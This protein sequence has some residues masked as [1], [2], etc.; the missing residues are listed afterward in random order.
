MTK[1]AFIGGT[2]TCGT[3]IM[4][5]ILSLHPKVASHSFEYRF[6]I[7]PDGIIDFYTTALHCWSPYIMDK[8]LRRLESF[9]MVLA[10]R[11]EGKEIYVNWELNKHFLGYEDAVRELMDELVDFKYKGIHYG[12]RG[13]RDIYYMVYRTK[14]EL[15]RI[16]GGF[17]RR[18]I[19]GYLESEGKELYVEDNTFNPLFSR[20]ILDL[21]PEAKFIHMLREPKDVIASLSKQ[22][23]APKDKIKSAIWTRNILDRINYL[24]TKIPGD[25]IITIDLYDLVD[26]TEIV[27][28]R[29][30]DFLK[31]PF[32]RRLLEIDLG[33]SHR[34]RWIKDF[35]SEELNS[36]R[37]ILY[38]D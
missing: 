2:G 9:L 27:L 12:I 16:L 10:K 14:K 4:K 8:K 35:S 7:D 30:C 13:K 34:D 25:S 33:R 20:D 6:I 11:Y 37:K 36:I 22:R 3:N 28:R 24:K 32:H 31:I 5:E 15:S 23:W 17:I 26:D 1:I 38:P 18:L 21:L 19:D 29:V